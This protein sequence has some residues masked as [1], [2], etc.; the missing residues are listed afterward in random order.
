MTVTQTVD[1][2]ESHRLVIDAPR[3]VP[4]G[5]SFLP[6]FPKALQKVGKEADL[7]AQRVNLSLQMILTLR[8]KISRTI[9]K[10]IGN[11]P[12]LPGDSKSLTFQGI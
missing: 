4:A 3:E 12:A 11:P 10:Y 6:L 1:I 9:C 7:D 2:P 5:R 8:L